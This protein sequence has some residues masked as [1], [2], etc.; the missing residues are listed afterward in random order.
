MFAC[1]HA[2]ELFQSILEE[3]RSRLIKVAGDKEGYKEILIG[4]IAQVFNGD[5]VLNTV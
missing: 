3:A 5:R 2:V 1:F 4:L